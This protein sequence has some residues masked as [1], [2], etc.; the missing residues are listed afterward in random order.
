MTILFDLWLSSRL[1]SA[2]LDRAMQ[3]TDLTPLEFGMYSLVGAY[4]PTTARQ[5]IAWTAMP[6]TTVSAMLGRMDNRDHLHREP[7]PDDGRSPLLSLS[8]AG[9][10]AMGEAHQAFRPAVAEVV[11][12][13]GDDHAQVWGALRRLDAALRDALGT[14]PHPGGPPE[15]S[16][17]PTAAVSYPGPMLT[18]DQEAEIRTYIEW[19]RHRDGQRGAPARRLQT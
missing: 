11:K 7:N 16:D 8:E 12:R 4:G 9:R 5:V 2:H 3:H 6:A 10:A 1:S 17:V 15:A 14:D 18:Q 19:M 13:L